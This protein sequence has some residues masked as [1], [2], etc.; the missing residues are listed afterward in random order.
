M[1]S[2]FFFLFFPFWFFFVFSKSKNRLFRVLDFASSSEGLQKGSGY[3]WVYKGISPYLVFLCLLV[4]RLGASTCVRMRMRVHRVRLC[5]KSGGS[6]W[7]TY[8]ASSKREKTK[9]R[10]LCAII[11]YFWLNLIVYHFKH[12]N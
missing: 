5:I 1:I 12:L 7:N 8:F 10:F 9:K 6:V 11:G 3:F 2:L 4:L